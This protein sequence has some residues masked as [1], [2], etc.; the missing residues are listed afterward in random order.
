[1][2]CCELAAKTRV[3]KNVDIMFPAEFLD[4]VSTE[5]QLS[6]DIYALILWSPILGG[7]IM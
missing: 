1:M 3:K 2:I 5:T 6:S 4:T 7:T